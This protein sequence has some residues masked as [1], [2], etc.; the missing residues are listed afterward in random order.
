[1]GKNPNCD[2]D[3]CHW[4]DGQIRV[5][6]LGGAGNALLCRACYQHEI[7][8]RKGRNR[9]LGKAFQFDIPDWE[10]LKVYKHAETAA[11]KNNF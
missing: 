11:R 7:E 9:E 1:M 8:W 4:S 2:N 6:P 3:Y 5:L 10:S